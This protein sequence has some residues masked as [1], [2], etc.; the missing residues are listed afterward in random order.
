M[1]KRK[2]IFDDLVDVYTSDKNIVHHE[3]YVQIEGETA[4]DA[5]G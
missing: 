1:V 4:V 5:E 3:L 2:S